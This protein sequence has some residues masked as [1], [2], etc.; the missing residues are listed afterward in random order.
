MGDGPGRAVKL[1]R[2]IDHLVS[3][4][5]ELRE[6]DKGDDTGLALGDLIRQN[7]EGWGLSLKGLADVVGCSKAHLWE[8]ESSRSVN[9]SAQLIGALADALRLPPIQILNAALTSQRIGPK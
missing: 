7:R 6:A 5:M 3:V 9:P 2:A 8:I 4:V 1:Q